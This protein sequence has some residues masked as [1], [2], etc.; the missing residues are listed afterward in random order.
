MT[1]LEATPILRLLTIAQVADA[2]AVS[3][4]TVPRLIRSGS[5]RV[6]RVGGQVRISPTKL[7]TYT[8]GGESGAA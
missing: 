3:V 6:V 2:L 5:L 1:T 7:T 8:S 4:S